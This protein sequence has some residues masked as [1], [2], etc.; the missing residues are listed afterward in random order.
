MNLPNLPTEN[1]YKFMALSGLAIVAFC[2]VFPLQRSNE[3]N[4]KIVEI[5]T[6]QKILEIEGDNITNDLMDALSTKGD[7]KP[8]EQAQFR[9]YLIKL[10]KSENSTELT[11]DWGKGEPILSIKE[12]A[13][14]RSRSNE[15]K[16]K[17]AEIRGNTKK[18]ELLLNEL[19][20]YLLIITIMGCFGSLI[21]IAG[22]YFWY[23][24]IQRPNDILLK[25][26][27]ENI[28]ISSDLK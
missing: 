4:F 3:I 27:I 10:F 1:L 21:S 28:K 5:E 23:S 25:K 22:F 20:T 24:L 13:I 11:K 12:Q 15:I 7:L 14:F 16:H 8:K 26:Q 2:I 9:D 18:A 6:Q 19:K 17:L